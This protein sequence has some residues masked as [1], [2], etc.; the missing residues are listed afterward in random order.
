MFKKYLKQIKVL[1]LY[2]REGIVGFWL[3]LLTGIMISAFI[4]G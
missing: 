2:Y 4:F 3:G 1:S